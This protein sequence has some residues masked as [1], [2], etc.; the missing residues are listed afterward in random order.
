MDS[1]AP[2]SLVDER[3]TASRLQLWL[4]FALSLAFALPFLDKPVHQDDWAYLRV[5]ELLA[6]NPDDILAET[7]TYQGGTISAGEG[8]LHGPV[9]I[10]TLNAC[11]AL[12]GDLET[13]VMLAHW[14]SALCLALLGLS[15]A[16]LAGRYGLPPLAMALLVTLSPVPLVL[17]GNLM[18][19]LPMLA[20]FSASLALGVRGLERGSL[21][22]L[23]AA[24]LVG[25]VAAL[26]RYHGLAVLPMLLALPLAWP[27][28]RF[29]EAT[30]SASLPRLR[31]RHFVPFALGLVIVAGFLARTIILKG[32]ADAGR[33]VNALD[34]LDEIDRT[35]CILAALGAVGGTLLAL[36]LGWLGAPKRLLAALRSR[37]IAAAFALGALLGVGVCVLA[38]TRHGIQPVG[39]NL[40]LQRVLLV[41]AGIGLVLAVRTLWR[42][43][44][45]EL[46]LS[47]KGGPVG[48][49]R[50][51]ENHGH[52]LF[53]FFWLV[54]YLV[55][56]WVTVPF[57]STRYALPALPAVVLFGALFTQRHLGARPLYVALVPM[58]LVGFGSAVADERAAEVYPAFAD[59]VAA[60]VA[61]DPELGDLWIWGELDF[62]WYL[63]EHPG[64]AGTNGGAG[65]QILATASN[66]PRSGDRIYKSAICTAGSDGLS[67]T[68]RLHPGVVGRMR[69]ERLKVYDDPWP[70]RIHNPYV[71]AGFYGAQGGILPFAWAASAPEDALGEPG[72]VPHDQ[73]QVYRIE[74]SNWFLESLGAAQIEAQRIEGMGMHNPHVESFLAFD[75]VDLGIEMRPSIFLAFPGRITYPEVAIGAADT[76]LELFVAEN[77][78]ANYYAGP[79]GIV[80]VRVNGEVAWERTIDARREADDRRWFP[81]RVDL[82]PYQGQTVAVSF[83]VSE[84]PWPD[85]P[86]DG[87]GVDTS[88]PPLT[89]FGFAE[90][91]VR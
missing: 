8:I 64:L 87:T 75:G 63:E 76:T 60:R 49:A 65:P 2:S 6:E 69:H 32:Q 55:A 79:G 78:R 84:G 21:R 38:E 26:I 58:A 53:L 41:L 7:T 37:G 5:A 36:A 61:A 59:E 56:A 44:G 91:R 50:W 43:A 47:S 90:P 16:S 66:A 72:T 17:A 34:A 46:P 22:T 18:T 52:L 11:L 15:I 82:T 81:V 51:R 70:V 39:F 40:W 45:R 25:A 33:A 42:G 27:R 19:D 83:E 77:D 89:F 57:G 10:H 31:A 80:R 4:A 86:A 29:A 12:G 74:D 62:R 13:A 68:Y 9:W 67:G 85:R 88:K 48:F 1:G 23:L 30:A 28:S 71:A 3:P 35:A 73:I 14:I 24:G 20:C 54:G